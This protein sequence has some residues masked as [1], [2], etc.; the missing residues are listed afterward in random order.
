MG[1]KN[2]V[3]WTV[4]AMWPGPAWRGGN[5]SEG[6]FQPAPT[7][8]TCAVVILMRGGGAKHGCRPWNAT[9]PDGADGHWQE[10]A[11]RSGPPPDR[12]HVAIQGGKFNK[13]QRE[14]WEEG[15]KRGRRRTF[16]SSLDD[17]KAWGTKESLSMA[18]M[19]FILRTCSSRETPSETHVPTEESPSTKACAH[20]WNTRR[21]ADIPCHPLK[22][23][24]ISFEIGRLYAIVFDDALWHPQYEISDIPLF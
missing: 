24:R 12:R 4:W 19:S 11:I 14:E 3:F 22:G 1:D 2:Y 13:R 20:T 21:R 6:H 16:T 5:V 15:S 17:L 7:T 10:C 18:S 9:A 23:G 8:T